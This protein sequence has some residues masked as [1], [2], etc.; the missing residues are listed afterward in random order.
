MLITILL[1][2]MILLLLQICFAL[3][4]IKI[5]MRYNNILFEEQNEKL[6]QKKED[7]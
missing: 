4:N 2:L 7:E 3:T 6:D 5:E 1:I